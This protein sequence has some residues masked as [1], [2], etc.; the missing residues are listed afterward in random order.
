[1]DANPFESP[2][3][4]LEPEAFSGGGADALSPYF[5]VSPTKLVAMGLATFSFYNLYW[6]YRQ[7]A[8]A[9]ARR[10]DETSPFWRTI[11]AILFCHELFQG[12]WLHAKG[13][14]LMPTYRPG[15]TTG[16]FILLSLSAYLPEPAWLVGFGTLV[17][18]VQ[19]QKTI[20]LIHAKVAPGAPRN[21]RFSAG[22][23]VVLVLGSVFWLLV[24]SGLFVSV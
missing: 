18:L 8:Q 2:A 15:L 12:I 7:F 9:K 19:V 5:A 22:N 14:D 11:F 16:V 13:E 23:W 20:N 3:T 17:P 4:E 10:G 21:D 1:M 24:I 6:F